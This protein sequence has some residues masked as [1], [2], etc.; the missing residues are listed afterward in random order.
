MAS[1]SLPLTELTGFSSLPTELRFQI[2]RL[3][4]QPRIVA[5]HSEK[6]AQPKWASNCDNPAALSVC[7][8][9]RA[10][11]LDHFT[12]VLP[13][14]KSKAG[15]SIPRPLYF[16]PTCDMLAFI[17]EV[18]FKRL[19]EI[20][21][22]VRELDPTHRGLRRVGVSL[23]CWAHNFRFAT[24]RIWED[25]LFTELEDLVLIMYDEQKPPASFQR[26]E[27]GLEPAQGMD[28]FARLLEMNLRPMANFCNFRI[29]NLAFNS[30]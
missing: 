14:F 18:G 1:D 26:G 15:I 20:F 8:E 25:S 9:S 30:S 2:W 27:A 13:M 4:F 16:S 23:S 10:L 11:A 24:L 17:G 6:D 28:S 7:S 3:T 21:R 19:S 12:V 29:M 22:L 5:I